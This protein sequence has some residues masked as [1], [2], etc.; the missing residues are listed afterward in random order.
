MTTKLYILKAKKQF[1]GYCDVQNI[2]VRAESET[3]AREIAM[4]SDDTITRWDSNYAT[5]EELYPEGEVGMM[6]AIK[7]VCDI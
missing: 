4:Y 3:E 7:V 1:T 6:E 2:V 5:C